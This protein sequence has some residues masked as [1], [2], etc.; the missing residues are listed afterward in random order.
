M[1]QRWLHVFKPIN[2][3]KLHRW[4]KK[5]KAKGLSKICKSF[6]PCF[7]LYFIDLFYNILVVFAMFIYEITLSINRCDLTAFFQILME[8]FLFFFFFLLISLTGTSK[9]MLNRDE[10]GKDDKFKIKNR[11]SLLYLNEFFA[12]CGRN[13]TLAYR[14]QIAGSLLA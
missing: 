13:L 5:I 14:K 11:K 6:V 10:K 12:N 3:F 1:A 8:C 9:L 7:W 2:I 4:N